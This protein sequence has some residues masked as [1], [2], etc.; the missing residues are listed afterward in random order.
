MQGT[1]V[2]LH[3]A[4]A[5]RHWGRLSP[6]TPQPRNWRLLTSLGSGPSWEAWMG[7]QRNQPPGTEDRFKEELSG[8]KDHQTRMEPFQEMQGWKVNVHKF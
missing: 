8:D 4:L 7:T 5:G 1:K 6:A 3:L 2:S